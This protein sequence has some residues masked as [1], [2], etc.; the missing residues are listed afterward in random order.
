MSC[1]LVDG[2]CTSATHRKRVPFEAHVLVKAL[3]ADYF[4][5]KK[6]EG[7]VFSQLIVQPFI[8]PHQA[9]STASA[10]V[11]Q[12]MTYPAVSHAMSSTTRPYPT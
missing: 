5:A 6:D 12:L 10:G 1:C 3:N 9:C 4:T 7:S 8:S 11:T 2:V